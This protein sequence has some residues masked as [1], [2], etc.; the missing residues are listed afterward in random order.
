MSEAVLSRR[1]KELG[2]VSIDVGSTSTSIAVFEE[3]V[4]IHSVVLPIGG[5]SVTNDIA[6]GLRTSIDTAEKLKIEYGSSLPD[7]ISERETIDLSQISKVDAHVVQKKQLA[8]IIQARYQEIFHMIQQELQAIDR[9]GNLPAGGILTGAAIK[10]PGVI[11]IAKETLNLPIQIGF[12]KNITG[13]IDKIDDPSFATADGLVL[14]GI[15][16]DGQKT[17]GGLNMN[18]TWQ[19]VKSWFKNLLP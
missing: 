1:Q 13:I 12:P 11:D 18:Q 3:G 6:I 8:S 17:F 2:V 10:M 14:W 4:L 15:H 16:N 9:D 7:N 5:E 19:G